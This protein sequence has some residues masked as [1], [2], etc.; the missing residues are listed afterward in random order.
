MTNKLQ[1]T[2]LKQDL[3]LRVRAAPSPTGK[4][5]LGNIRTYL[6]C[7]LLAKKHNGKI[8]LRIEDSDQKRSIA[9][10]VEAMVEAY[11]AYGIEFDEGPH[12]GGPNGPYVQSERSEIYKKYAEELVDKGGAYYCFCTE[13]RLSKLKIEQQKLGLKTRYDGHCRNVPIAEA[14]ERI[15]KG[16][17]YVI[18]LKVPTE[19][20]TICHCEVFGTY[21]IKNSAIDDQVLLKSNGLPTY[22]FGVVV[23][24]H[25]M[26][27]TL[28]TRGSEYITSYPKDVLL[29][30]F[31]GWK[32]PKF[33]HLPVILNPDG[34]GK[35][36]KR[37]GAMPALTYLR[38]GYLREAVINYVM[39]CGWAPEPAKAHQDEIYSLEELIQLFDIQRVNKSGAKFDQKKMDSINAKHIR[40]LSDEE[41][42]SAVIYWAKN[43][44]LK[45]FITDSI[46]EAQ[47]WEPDLKTQVEKY[48]SHWEADLEKFSKILSLIQERVTLLSEI[49]DQIAFFYLTPALPDTTKVKGL[50]G[51]S[52]EELHK[53]AQAIME[54]MS[55]YA[56]DA[57][58]WSQENW[59][60]D[61]RAIGDAHGWK[62]ADVFM[63]LRVLVCGSPF[64]PP[65]FE[66]LQI[67]GKN[68]VVSR[69]T[70]LN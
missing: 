69:I 9:N 53:I 20:E 59:V 38:K 65:L 30:Q 13:E 7:Y 22:H 25:L 32:M 29:Y 41:F 27:I 55:S 1:T 43:Y 33:A 44:V 66:A 4:V 15:A 48:L 2:E 70:K 24:D 34:K 8:V 68:D 19:G 47:P 40:K 16:E 17:K 37:H 63:L 36:S 58:T 52:K 45:Q 50:E 61:M 64:S 5:Q 23:D 62:H 14:R 54:K 11:S 21:S 39:L 12:V 42:R 46:E 28:A 67:L 3:E 10:G 26:G 51:R 56:E 35:L 49:P 60:A 18:R 31:F 57:A 6:M